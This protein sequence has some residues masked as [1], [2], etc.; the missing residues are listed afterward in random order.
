MKSFKT[1]L[2]M[3]GPVAWLALASSLQ[4]VGA[5]LFFK[6]PLDF[7]LISTG[8]FIT[9]GIYL[10]NR[11]TDKEDNVNCPD[12]KFYFQEKNKILPIL[13]IVGSIFILLTTSR[14]LPWHVFMLCGGILYSISII[15]VIKKRSIQFIRLKD[16]ILVKNLIVSLIWGLSSFIIAKS[17]K[18]AIM[19]ENSLDLFIIISAFCLTTFINT[20]SCD[21]RDVTGDFYSGTK[22]LATYFG[23]NKIK[24]GFLFI[25]LIACSIILLGHFYDKISLGPT[26]LFLSSVIWTG[27][28]ASP[29]YIGKLSKAISEP[30]IDTQQIFCGVALIL[31]SII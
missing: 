20:T 6:L 15:P 21:V 18:G 31:L 8:F 28:V 19:P 22:T 12:R 3:T 16:I 29:I 26:I 11:F 25:G 7:I 10:L 27:L 2:L 23:K 5:M 9:F 17:Q 13:F 30:L 4:L 1:F 14:L 24:I